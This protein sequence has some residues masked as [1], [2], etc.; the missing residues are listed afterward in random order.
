[1]LDIPSISAV[2]A[3]IGVLIGVI[4]AVLEVRN[5]V[6]QRQAELFMNLYDH[7]NDPEFAKHWAKTV[8]Q[9]NWKD[10]DDWLKKYGPETNVEAYSS[11]AAIGNYFK[12]I[13]VLVNKKLIDISL[14]ENLMSQTLFGYWE[15]YEPVVKGFREHYKF[16]EAWKWV[17]YL[18]NELKKRQQSAT[19]Q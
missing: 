8:F 7:Y 19:L 1:M 5:L 14:A 3:A 4:I 10:F 9:W 18:H 11:W 12:G 13:G 16:P 6:K 15:K 17:E 2:V